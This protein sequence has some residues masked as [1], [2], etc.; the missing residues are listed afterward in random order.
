MC[1]ACGFLCCASDEME[2]CGCDSCG[3]LACLPEEDWDDS[4]DDDSDC[5][6]H[7]VPFDEEC[8]ECEEEDE[9]DEDA[10]A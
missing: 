2:G 7:G 10:K 9:E 8:E 4:G 6:H 3:V 1:N 5:C